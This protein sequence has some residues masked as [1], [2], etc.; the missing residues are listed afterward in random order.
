MS[1]KEDKGAEDARKELEK[2]IEDTDPDWLAKR[3]EDK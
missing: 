3:L 2:M 1:G